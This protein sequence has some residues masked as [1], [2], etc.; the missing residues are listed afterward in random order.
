VLVFQQHVLQ[1]RCYNN[2]VTSHVL[3][4]HV[5]T[6]CY[7]TMLQHCVIAMSY[8]IMLQ[9]SVTPLCYNNVLHRYVTTLSYSNRVTTI[10]VVALISPYNLLT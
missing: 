2:G 4:Q 3:Q 6:L 9:Q 8:N 1:H 7:N 10:R 5:T